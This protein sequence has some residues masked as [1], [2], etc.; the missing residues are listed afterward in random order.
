MA[1][2]ITPNRYGLPWLTSFLTRSKFPL[3]VH[4]GERRGSSHNGKH[5]ENPTLPLPAKP[6]SSHVRVDSH[7]EDRLLALHQVQVVQFTCECPAADANHNTDVSGIGAALP[8]TRSPSIGRRCLTDGHIGAPSPQ[9]SAG[10]CF[11]DQPTL[12]ETAAWTRGR[13]SFPWQ[14]RSMACCRVASQSLRSR[15][16]Q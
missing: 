6:I 10:A 5:A 3:C 1:A 12:L 11:C 16:Y 7:H 4:K 14:P 9:R 15:H 13:C 2:W 8:V